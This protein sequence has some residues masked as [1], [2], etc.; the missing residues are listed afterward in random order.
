MYIDINPYNYIFDMNSTKF[1]LKITHL[2][3]ILILLSPLTGCTVSSEDKGVAQNQ[4]ETIDLETQEELIPVDVGIAQVKSIREIPEY[5][6]TTNPI[7][8]VSIRSQV[9]GRLIDLNVNIG[10]RVN[11]GEFLAQLD[12]SLLA[13]EVNRAEAELATLESELARDRAEINNAETE[14][15]RTLVELEQAQNDAKTNAFLAQEGAIARQQADTF[16]TAA[17]VAEKAVTSA[18]EQIQIQ[19]EVVAATLGRIAAQKALIAQAKQRQSYA[20]LF[21][22]MNGV[23]LERL[24]EPGDLITPG[25]E[26]LQLGD[27]SSI[28]I[29]V[30]VSELELSDIQVGQLVEVRLDAFT[31]QSFVGR[32]TR[33]SPVANSTAR[34]VPV[35]VLIKNPNDRIASGLLARV[36]FQPKVKQ[37]VI[38][39]RSA[40]KT[41]NN[42]TIVFVIENQGLDAPIQ[43][44]A[45]EVT[46]GE[47]ANNQ[48][49]ILSGISPGEQ[50]VI[51]SEEPLNNGD[52]VELSALSE[53]F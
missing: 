2:G 12:D 42:Q 25:Q 48:V 7:L 28:K 50:F 34:Q 26:V 16:K 8:E 35:E 41:E 47:S 18:R 51:N 1:N 21:S 30:P 37:R 23:V 49:E 33:I 11:S 40:L 20:K 14:Y 22:P 38:I 52:K 13:A 53:G 31:Q 43:V 6:G 29:I 17:K 39:P 9:E 45:R 10:D 24:V 32:V 3:I 4:P 36:R 27:F 19:R 44:T 5:V 46:L 15:Q